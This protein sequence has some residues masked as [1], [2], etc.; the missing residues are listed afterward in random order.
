MGYAATNSESKKDPSVQVNQVSWKQKYKNI[1]EDFI[2]TRHVS[3]GNTTVQQQ[4][5][6]NM[7]KMYEGQDQVLVK[8]NLLD[9]EQIMVNV[10][11]ADAF[12]G[13]LFIFKYTF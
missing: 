11:Q 8:Q 12:K 3:A 1:D 4:I 10:G 6:S 5:G 2:Q 13:F 9:S 7:L